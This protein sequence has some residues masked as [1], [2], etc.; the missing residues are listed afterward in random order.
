MAHRLHLVA[1]SVKKD[2]KIVDSSFDFLNLA[3]F[4][5]PE[6]NVP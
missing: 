1:D 5:T 2:I 3:S 4:L 6:E